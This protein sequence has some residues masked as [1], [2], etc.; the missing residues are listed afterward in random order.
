MRRPY[1]GYYVEEEGGAKLSFRQVRGTER[2]LVHYTPAADAVARSRDLNPDLVLP[3]KPLLLIEGDQ[4]A[5]TAT[6]H[7][8]TMDANSPNF[9]QPRH[10][11]LATITLAKFGLNW[12][13]SLE[14]VIGELERLPPGFVR[15]PYR[16]LGI[17]NDVRQIPDTVQRLDGVTDLLI[18]KG[19]TGGPQLRGSTYAIPFGRF[20]E[21]R[22]EIGRVHSRAL[23]A[24]RA[25]K[26]TRL[27]DS[28][29]HPVDP[30]RF[31]LVGQPYQPDAVV[32]AVGDGIR[33][34]VALSP[35]DATLVVE[36]ASGLV[37]E[38]AEREPRQLL[39]LT[40]AVETVTLEGMIAHM[41]ARMRER[42]D[43]RNWQRFLSD[44]AF[45]LRL[46]FGVPVLL[47]Q[48]EATVGGRTYGGSGDKRTD[49]LLKAAKSG[50]LSI[51]EIKRP[52]TELLDDK[53][54]R[55]GIHA[56]HGKLSGA[57]AQ[58]MDQRW[59][60]QRNNSLLADAHRRLK[61]ESGAS[62][63]EAHP[64]TYAVQC[65]VVAGTTPTTPDRLKS[66]E[67]YR[68]G[69]AGIT[70]ITYD[71]LLLKLTNLLSLLKDPDAGAFAVPTVTTR[72]PKSRKRGKG[73]RPGS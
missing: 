49:F 41:R 46:A 31:P 53:V 8:L 44:N 43:E 37:R 69:L 28:L 35:A 33:Q 29:L 42:H 40:E 62:G 65:I 21:A 23:L 7:P 32:K 12:I 61:A 34:G 25:E 50:N 6:I 13:E 51:V 11:R 38:V 47:F 72:K 59:H 16:G 39:R 18:T 26:G 73:R 57:V 9:L 70:V 22:K 4:D 68:N 58:A 24:A 60:L 56:P 19:A 64:E 54:Y 67:L 20:D 27:Q 1:I 71:E 66:L 63:D 30:E 10:D 14:D 52:D 48:G 36:A 2:W 45:I 55:G 15:N 3:T 5:D 17:A